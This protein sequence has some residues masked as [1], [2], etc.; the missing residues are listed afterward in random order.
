MTEDRN[1]RARHFTA[2]KD[3]PPRA[4][5]WRPSAGS[6]RP[7]ARPAS[8]AAR[9]QHVAGHARPQQARPQQA[10]PQQARQQARPASEAY[11]A[12]ARPSGRRASG[13]RPGGT[14]APDGRNLVVIGAGLLV[15]LLIAFFLVPRCTSALFGE[16][17]KVESGKLVSV[18]IPDGASGADIARV[19]FEAGVIA[20]EREFKDAVHAKGAE[21]SMKSGTFELTCGDSLDNIVSILSAGSNSTANRITVAEG[22]TLQ[23]TAAAV[24]QQTSISA[25]D[26]L[27][28]AKAS[29]Y[30]SS[31]PFLAEAA[32]DSLEGFLYP[33]TY[34]FDGREVTADAIIRDMLDQYAVE[35]ADVDLA[36]ARSKIKSAYNLDLTNYDI[37]KV[38]SIIEREA[39]SDTDRPLVA[40]AIYNRLRDGMALQSDATMGY[41]TGGEVTAEDLTKES[42][43]N[44]YLNQGL[45][46]TPICTPGLEALKA[47]A[48][49]AT[50]NYKYFLIIENG[51]YSNHTF[52]ETYEEHERAIEKAKSEGWAA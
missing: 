19:L 25:S 15:V 32:N 20:N 43:Y 49:P 2:R 44:T 4:R 45:T 34:D 52:S 14:G 18:R 21:S 12:Q 30:V 36:G 46:P 51:S 13:K 27:A 1:P 17:Q 38:A 28:Q 41:V 47:A 48:D 10:R 6:S 37:L 35:I 8:H 26:F 5:A 16:T 40:S 3:A 22:L 50:T 23:K 31:Y 33:K 24:E 29:N 39:I 11:R 7:Q 42:P 9:Q